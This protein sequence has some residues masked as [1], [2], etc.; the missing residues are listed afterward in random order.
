MKSTTS[1]YKRQYLSRAEVE[2]VA[3]AAFF[4]SSEFSLGYRTLKNNNSLFLVNIQ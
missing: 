1:P 2:L 3:R 4:R